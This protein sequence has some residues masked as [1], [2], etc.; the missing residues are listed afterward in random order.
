VGVGTDLRG[1]HRGVRLDAFT[2]Q[3]IKPI[4]LASG[5]PFCRATL[6]GLQRSVTE[7]VYFLVGTARSTY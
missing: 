1:S 7:S 3:R 2:K 4:R 5:K 6:A